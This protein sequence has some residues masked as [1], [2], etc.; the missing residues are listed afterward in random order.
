MMLDAPP[1]PD[2]DLDH[3]P[4]QDGAACLAIIDGDVH[5]APGALADLKP[6]MSAR[7][8]EHLTT[9]GTRR[10]HGMSFEPYPKS[11]PRACRRDAW[12]EGGGAPGSN[13]DLIRSQYLDHYGIAFGILGPL[14]IT[15]QSE[16]NLD[17]AAALASAVNDW[18]RE[19]F[20]RREPRLR[21]AIVVPYEDG[22][23]SAK[24]IDRC[25]P[26]PAYAQVFM[27]T[28]SAEPAGNRRY[29]PIY[30]AAERNG[31][32][33]ALHVFGA[34]GHP[35][36]GTGWPSYYVEEG[37]GHSTSCQT[38][39][40]SLVIEGVFERFPKLKV[41]IVEG[42]FAWLAPLSWRLDKL[43]ER[44]RGEVPHLKRRPSEYIREHIW[45][46]TQPMEEPEDRRH[47]L[48]MMAWIGW[49][50]LLFAS[51]YPHWDF[52]DPF[53]AFPAGLA[54]DRTQQILT[55]NAKAVY[56]LP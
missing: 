23:A 10:R 35:Y 39:V 11:A 8:W 44:M 24:E 37:A 36:T 17:F 28:R 54:T 14:G 2:A 48:D 13:L 46:T 30:E 21:S 6:Y 43:Y 9:Y 55:T 5:P 47:V 15:G 19:V 52:D 50:R 45:V 40:T 41:V 1:A 26:D 18:Q 29:W 49:D 31:L 22:A 38:V 20:T 42:G 25:A 34:S 7:W 56:R 3:R 51:D 12:P 4:A 27:L 16:I 32:P 33:V 53:R